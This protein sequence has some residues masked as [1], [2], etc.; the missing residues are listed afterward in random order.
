MAG[1]TQDFGTEL[2]GYR[3]ED[4]DHAIADL[5]RELIQA[6][7]ERAEAA[8][9]IKRVTAVAEDLQAELDETGT[10]TYAGLGTKLESTLRVAEEIGRAS[11]R[12]RVLVA[13]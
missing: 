1:E 3:K 13:V 8:K 12:E 5:R 2:R 9:E 6:N 4:V 7:H 10:P 11:C